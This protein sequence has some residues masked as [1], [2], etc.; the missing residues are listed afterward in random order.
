MATDDEEL[1]KLVAPQGSSFVP[2]AHVIL[3]NLRAENKLLRRKTLS[4]I[5]EEI[6]SLKV[7]FDQKCNVSTKQLVKPFKARRKAIKLDSD[8]EEEGE[9]ETT[10]E[11]DIFEQSE[12][13]FSVYGSVENLIK[14]LV[15]SLSDPVEKCR[16]LAY[17]SLT[18][19]V[20]K[21]GKKSLCQAVPVVIPTLVERLAQPELIESS[22]EVRLIAVNFIGKLVKKCQKEMIPFIDDLLEIMLVTLGDPYH[23]VRIR[24]CEV[25]S[26]IAKTMPEV[27]H[28]NSECLVKPL[29]L[30]LTH[31]QS[32]LRRV[33]AECIGD[34]L[35]YG[36]HKP[37]ENYVPHLIQR[38]FD[39][40][41]NVRKSV[42][43]VVGNWMMDFT[44][45]Y[46]H[47]HRFLPV[48]MS[49]LC[50]E[51]PDVS[52]TA[53]NLWEKIGERYL[54]E[55]IKDYKDHVDFPAESPK[56]Y[57]SGVKRPNFGCRMLTHREVCKLIPG[58]THEIMDW[59]DSNRQKSAQLLYHLV[60]NC[61]EKMTMHVEP[62]FQC[63]FRACLDSNPVVI[64]YVLDSATLIGYFVPMSTCWPLLA[65]NLTCSPSE[66]CLAVTCSY[67]KGVDPSALP[68]YLN[69][70]MELMSSPEICQT[71]HDGKLQWIV[72]ISETVLALN[73]NAV[74]DQCPQ[75]LFKILLII[76]SMS[77]SSGTITRAQ[78]A[79]DILRQFCGLATVDELFGLYSGPILQDIKDADTEWTLNTTERLIFT[80]ILTQAG[81]GIER[82]IDVVLAILVSYLGPKRDPE[83]RLSLFTELAEIL[84]LYSEVEHSPQQT[85][86]IQFFVKTIIEDILS[87]SLVWRAGKSAGAL[88]VAALNC[89]LTVLIGKLLKIDDIV[90][91]SSNI[92][93]G[94]I[95]LLDE[96]LYLN[97]LF[98]V[99]C[100]GQLFAC[101]ENQVEIDLVNKSYPEL[102]KRMD[103]E[104]KE[105]RMATSAALA[106][107]YSNLPVDYTVERFKA[108]LDHAVGVLI[109]H[110]DDHDEEIQESV[111]D[112]L[113]I[114]GTI[115]S[116]VVISKCE[117]FK[118]KNRSPTF[119][120][121]LIEK[122]T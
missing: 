3:S 19:V 103:D 4:G 118:T 42:V 33:V 66:G 59:Q 91:F 46:S 31:Q 117:S 63:M 21:S 25:T 110:L 27:F 13:L 10:Q 60:L 100:L 18:F 106:E 62:I 90:T 116:E 105:V 120:N 74:A 93:S 101:C 16:E 17:E 121:R 39:P 87:K 37:A 55:N 8:D 67:L 58:V 61:E 43:N 11:G 22:E 82:N 45:R 47:F 14:S 98:S 50:D 1:G 9:I 76:A 20:E 97:R 52:E 51:S 71:L 65:E 36:S 44:D 72:S 122:L 89:L 115:C 77:R 6:K 34:V 23:E 35:Q 81:S 26:L 56:H 5:L 111:L 28:Y 75:L 96:Q 85:K 107:V 2:N 79:M 104:N 113:H 88:R 83:V 57:P 70:I 80:T 102:L 68:T 109:V 49:G 108:H 94:C 30:S 99:K 24:S 38:L 95:G 92:A 53:F 40:N 41:Q 15:L 78:G 32:R 64:K 12:I 112:T 86:Q 7:D 114:I 84:K 48:I 119:C 73:P 29:C 54:D 69:E